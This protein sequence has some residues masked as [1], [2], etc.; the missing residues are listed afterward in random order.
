MKDSKMYTLRK[1]ART[2]IWD[3]YRSHH[4]GQG[5]VIG[6]QSRYRIQ[7]FNFWNYGKNSEIKR[8]PIVNQRSGKE[9]GVMER[10]GERGVS[11]TV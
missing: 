10:N 6:S 2:L 3:S 1:R 7:N 8:Q 5:Q 11:V 4:G 9:I